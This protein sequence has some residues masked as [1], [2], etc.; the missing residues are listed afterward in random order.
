MRQACYAH[1]EVVVVVIGFEGDF[2]LRG[3]GIAGAEVG[4]TGFGQSQ[5]RR[6][7]HVGLAAVDVQR[8]MGAFAAFEGVAAF[9]EEGEG[10]GDEEVEGV[11]VEADF[12]VAAGLGIPPYA[13]QTGAE[14]GIGPGIVV[15]DGD[16]PAGKVDRVGIAEAQFGV[17]GQGDVKVP[18]AGIDGQRT[19]FNVGKGCAVAT[20]VVDGG[21]VGQGRHVE[22]VDGQGFAGPGF[23]LCVLPVEQVQP[24]QQAQCAGMARV[25]FEGLPGK[26]FFPCKA[27]EGRRIACVQ[28]G[29]VGVD[30]QGLFVGLLC[31]G[32][33]VFLLKQGRPGAQVVGV[34]GVHTV[35]QAE[36][37][38]G[39]AEDT[40]PCGGAGGQPEIVGGSKGAFLIPAEDGGVETQG[41]PPPAGVLEQP[42]QHVGAGPAVGPR[43]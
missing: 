35:G 34:A 39:V 15:L 3:V 19:P 16:G 27:A 33:V 24:R 9:V 20:Q 43:P 30:G 25:D 13:Q 28:V 36:G 11:A 40:Q 12:E 4:I 42:A 41:L 17:F 7:Q 5:H 18:G 6:A 23:G 26:L 29:V 1:A 14:R 38:V 32:G 21:Q 37:L 8:E 10:V 22:G 2:A 31:V